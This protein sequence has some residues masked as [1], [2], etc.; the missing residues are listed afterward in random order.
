MKDRDTS[1]ALFERQIVEE[2]LNEHPLE[3]LK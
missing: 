1:E 3:E 2:I